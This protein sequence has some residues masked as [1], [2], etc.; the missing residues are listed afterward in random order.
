MG[1]KMRKMITCIT[2]ALVMLMLNFYVND[3]FASRD[4][5]GDTEADVDLNNVASVAD[6]DD[7]GSRNGEFFSAMIDDDLSSWIADVSIAVDIYNHTHISYV[8]NYHLMYAVNDGDGWQIETVDSNGKVY[9]Y[10]SIAVDSDGHPH[11]SYCKNYHLN[12]AYHDGAQWN[13]TTVDWTY[14][15]YSNSIALDSYDRPHISYSGHDYWEN[16]SYAYYNGAVWHKET[17]D[18]YGVGNT[19]SIAIDP[20]GN[21][22]ISYYDRT[23][24]DLKHAFFNSVVWNNETVDWHGDVGKYSSIAVDQWNVTHIS[25]INYSSRSLKYANFTGFQWGTHTLNSY[26]YQTSLALDSYSCPH[27]CATNGSGLSYMYYRGNQWYSETIPCCAENVSIAMSPNDTP[28]IAIIG[29]NKLQYITIDNEEPTLEEDLS[30]TPTTGDTFKLIINDSDNIGISNVKRT[31]EIYGPHRI[32]HDNGPM[33]ITNDGLWEVNITIPYDA[34]YINYSFE[35]TDMAENVFTTDF[36][37]KDVM[38]ND[39]PA[40]RADESGSPT[41]GDPFSF[42][43]NCSDNIN[44]SAG[45]SFKYDDPNA[46]CLNKGLYDDGTNGDFYAG[47]GAFTSR[48][49]D[50]PPDISGIYYCFDLYDDAGNNYNTSQNWGYFHR[51]VIDN[52]PP[53]L[54]EDLSNE[55]ATTGDPFLFSISVDDNILVASAQVTYRFDGQNNMTGNLADSD[56]GTAWAVVIDV[57]DDAVEMEYRFHL[58]DSAGNGVNTN[59][60]RI[61]VTDND[62]PQANAG[63]DIF[64]DQY[65]N[66]SFSAANSTDNIGIVNYTW[67]FRYNEVNVTLHGRDASFRFDIPGTYTVTLTVTDATGNFASD[68]LRATVRDI[69]DYTSP[70]A[71]AGTDLYADQSDNVT[72]NGGKSSDNVGVTNYTWTFR[73]QNANRT[74]YGLKPVFSFDV[75]GVYN[76]TLT[77]TDAAGNS[78]K[79]WVIITVKDTKNP[80]AVGT[81]VESDIRAGDTVH[82]DS[83][84]CSDNVGVFNYTWTFNDDGAMV[85]YGPSPDYVFKTPGTYTVT[86]TVADA[87]GNEASTF[88]SVTVGEKLSP[89]ASQGGSMSTA[90]IVGVVVVVIVAV[91]IIVLFLLLKRRKRPGKEEEAGMDEETEETDEPG[92]ELDEFEVAGE[93]EKDGGKGDIAGDGKDTGTEDDGEDD[94]E[95]WSDEGRAE[96]NET[97]VSEE[98]EEW[99]EE[100]EEEEWNAEVD[101]EPWA[102]HAPELTPVPDTMKGVI[103]G[104]I[105]QSKLGS[106]GFATVYKAVDSNGELVAIKLPKFIDE[107]V[108]SSVLQKFKAEADIWKK[109]KHRNIVEFYNSDIRPVPYMVIEYMEGG[110]LSDVMKKGPLPVDRVISLIREIMSGFAYAH[111]MASVHRDIKPEN[112]LFTKDGTPKISDWGI[113]KFMAS[114]SASKTIGTKGTLIYSS[115]EQISQEKYGNVDWNTDVFQLGIVFYEMLTGT[116]PFIADDPIGI[117]HNIIDKIPVPPSS[118]RSGIPPEIDTVILRALEKEK[119]KR[120]RSADT[121]LAKIEEGLQDREKNL[122]H[123]RSM[124]NRALKDGMISPEEEEMLDGF[125]ERY[126]ISAEEHKNIWNDLET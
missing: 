66:A 21:P 81:T 16:L 13:I 8:K 46:S 102:E 118:L 42:V 96:E 55:N 110:N 77:V 120:F 9:Y 78:D 65:L 17:V 6:V 80:K 87:A 48:G 107:T 111:R 100:D 25:Y 35:I 63:L 37:D 28:S 122:V 29:N 59:S 91:F 38:D 34:Y 3:D 112:L 71:D 99:E 72:L 26:C 84:N 53:Q 75:P 20:Y 108:D 69:W 18:P 119:D 62:K 49:I 27:I 24:G 70:M 113:G 15:G 92:D 60:T 45:V 41:T 105:I 68:V 54:V 57:P 123:Y 5:T 51:D 14:C 11:I 98:D 76:V 117:M 85:L 125:R 126:G 39:P 1:D 4:R 109:L 2:L 114:E 83:V 88:F 101:D 33:N 89:A 58:N 124:L 36:F 97:W 12:Y 31:C 22:H 7:L 115:P 86:L 82:F 106:G 121:M 52:D 43:V 32:L 104:Y 73:Y 90:V 19:T 56:F 93:A 67:S 103:P 44:L 95:I 74:L 30:G 61:D 47:D 79:D 64:L 50:I 116:N 40:F 23:N 94:E 10:N